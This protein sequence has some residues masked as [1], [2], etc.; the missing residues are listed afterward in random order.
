MK[1][2][3]PSLLPV[4]AGAALIA[5]AGCTKKAATTATGD[6]LMH[7]AVTGTNALATQ[8]EICEVVQFLADKGVPLDE[9]NARGRTPIDIADV[10]PIDKAVELLTKLIIQS[11]ATPKTPSKR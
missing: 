3:H 9:K 5:F 1:K 10:L 4:I 6:T 8:A 7:M 11:G 2:L